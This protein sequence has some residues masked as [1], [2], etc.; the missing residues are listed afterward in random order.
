M[1]D[2]L[3]KDTDLKL[4]PKLVIDKK[5]KHAS[6]MSPIKGNTDQIG[7]GNVIMLKA[8]IDRKNLGIRADEMDDSDPYNETH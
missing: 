2:P 8:T 3:Q 5:S 1:L 7:V 6:P 4:K